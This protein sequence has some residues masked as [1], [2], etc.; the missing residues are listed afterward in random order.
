MGNKSSKKE[1][2]MTTK[3]G[4]TFVPP[5]LE[6]I[7]IKK[8][9]FEV[10]RSKDALYVL[11]KEVI[12]LI[13]EFLANDPESVYAFATVSK[14]YYHLISNTETYKVNLLDPIVNFSRICQFFWRKKRIGKIFVIQ[15]TTALVLHVRQTVQRSKYVASLVI[16]DSLSYLSLATRNHYIFTEYKIKAKHLD[17]LMITN[18]GYEFEMVLNIESKYRISGNRTRRFDQ[19][20]WPVDLR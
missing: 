3:N 13:I 14:W 19:M 11:P 8:L 6:S 17:Y 2:R 18:P 1:S 4:D 20:K 5:E 10:D 16:N 9:I 7:P 15:L 12:P